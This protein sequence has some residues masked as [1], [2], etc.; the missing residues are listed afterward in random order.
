MYFSYVLC[1][2]RDSYLFPRQF[3]FINVEL[4]VNEKKK[5]GNAPL[6]LA[7]LA[8]YKAFIKNMQISAHVYL[9]RN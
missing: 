3:A 9:Y 2:I 5:I 4:L 6:V 7:L 8:R 1:K